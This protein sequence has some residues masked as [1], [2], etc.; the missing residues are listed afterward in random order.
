[1][2]VE[3]G[4]VGSVRP[5][6]GMVHEPICSE[7]SDGGETGSRGSLSLSSSVEGST[8]RCGSGGERRGR[9][10]VRR[11]RRSR[12]SAFRDSIV[13]TRSQRAVSERRF[14]AISRRSSVFWIICR[15]RAR[16]R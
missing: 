14:A 10:F 2:S 4:R 16:R 11:S 15:M 9:L 5:V 8:S 1:M 13:Q 6:R 12:Q 3:E 7:V